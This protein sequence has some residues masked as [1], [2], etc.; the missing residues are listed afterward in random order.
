MSANATVKK[1]APGGARNAA[2][3]AVD[4]PPA[5]V[6]EKAEGTDVT[7][8]LRLVDATG[9]VLMEFKTTAEGALA[10]EA[11]QGDL[12]LRAPN[13]AV[14]IDA[15]RGVKVRSGER[16]EMSAARGVEL[17]T[18]PTKERAGA[19]LAM[20][21]D[22]VSLVARTIAAAAHRAEATLEE[23]SVVAKALKT[24]AQTLHHVAGVIETR[25]ERIVE[26]A[27]DSYREA[28]DLAETRAG[29]V[30]MVATETLAT[31]GRRVLFKAREDMKLKGDKIHLG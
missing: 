18:E 27:K 31:L 16:L 22:A 25:A 30:K 23:G 12:R 9:R 17:R 29:R 7:G 13:G 26:K 5:A 20:E 3:R 19:R 2:V 24:T 1:L 8:P 10:I 4:P 14:E 21:H 28:E 11:L 15:K 6:T